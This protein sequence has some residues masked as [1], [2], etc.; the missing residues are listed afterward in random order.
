M[1][2][3]VY[4][5]L[6]FE[7][8][9]LL[10]VWLQSDGSGYSHKVDIFALGLILFE[11]FHEPFVTQSERVTTLLRVRKQQLPGYFSSS[12]PDQASNMFLSYLASQSMLLFL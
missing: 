9:S 5:P 1:L 8:T 3:L 7:V 11:L 12:L 10:C 4:R 6:D 2:L